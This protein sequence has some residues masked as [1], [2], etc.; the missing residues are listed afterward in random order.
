MSDEFEQVGGRTREPEGLGV[1]VSREEQILAARLEAV[2]RERDEY[3][4]AL[5][6]LKAE[7][8]NYRK[9]ISRE[10]ADLTA[11]AAERVLKQLRRFG[12]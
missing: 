2:E 8:D 7:F 9:R 11:R 6:R 5:K 12:R 4:D 1:E 3:L 10:Q